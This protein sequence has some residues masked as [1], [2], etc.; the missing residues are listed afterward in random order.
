MGSLAYLALNRLHN[1]RPYHRLDPGLRIAD[2][3]PRQPVSIDELTGTPSPSRALCD[4]FWMQ[5]SWDAIEQAVG[6]LHVVD[7]GCGSGRY[8]VDFQRWSGNRV[9]R[10]LG[11]DVQPHANWP[12]LSMAHRHLA[13]TSGRAEDLRGLIP[14]GTNVIVSQSTF[15]HVEDDLGAFDR[16]DE[17]VRREARPLLQIHLVPSQACLWTYLWHGYRQ[18]TPRTL[19]K[20]TARVGN[21]SERM[22][23]RLGGRACNALHAR[24]ITW[25][26]LVRRGAD[27]RERDPAAYREALRDAIVRDLDRPQPSPAFYALLIHSNGQRPLLA[28]APFAA[29]YDA[30]SS[31]HP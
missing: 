27:A 19:S 30:Q 1:A 3:R 17:Y 25:P 7:V 16:I 14:P 8:G 23:V 4:L 29:R 20:I 22:V 21:Q 13:F 11:V 28:Q 6:S 31:L 10:Y 2:F 9:V 18:Y 26:V 15:E 5:M 12:R 24:V